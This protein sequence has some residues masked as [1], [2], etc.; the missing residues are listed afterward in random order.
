MTA[1]YNYIDE[2]IAGVVQ[3]LDHVIHGR[4]VAVEEINFGRPVFGYVGEDEKVGTYHLDVSKI[5]YSADFVALNQIDASVGGVSITPVVF[6]TDHLTTINLVVAAIDALANVEAVLD[7]ADTNNRTILV[8]T[9][10]DEA[11]A[12]SEV[13]LGAS[14]AT[15]TVTTHS[16]MVFMGVSTFTQNSTGVYEQ[17][18]SVSIIVDGLVSV[19]PVA[20]V[21]AYAAAYVDN[22]GADIGELSNAGFAINARYTQNALANGFSVLEVSGK[23]NEA[24]ATTF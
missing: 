22:S 5:V 8:R 12:T 14:Q 7:P 19:S 4:F 21:E 3:D 1:A 6:A 11:V 17:Y 9:K 13:T 2:S 20:A 18:D 23:S 24:Y 10:F 15:V 16:A